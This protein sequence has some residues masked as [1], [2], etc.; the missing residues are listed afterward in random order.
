LADIR[1]NNYVLTP[2]RYIDFKE[3]EDDG[4]LFEDKIKTLT[5]TMKEQMDKAAELDKAIKDNLAKIG[6]KL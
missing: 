6:F 2:G 3:A 5:A 1:K 4:I